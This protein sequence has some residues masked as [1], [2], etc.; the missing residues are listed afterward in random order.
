[1]TS[2]F[3]RAPM[4]EPNS[5]LW[6]PIGTPRAN[7][8]DGPRSCWRRR[9]QHPYDLAPSEKLFVPAH[10]ADHTAPRVQVGRRSP[11]GTANRRLKSLFRMNELARLHRLAFD[12]E[13]LAK[14]KQPTICGTKDL[15]Y[16]T[17][18]AKLPLNRVQ[19]GGLAMAFTREF[20]FS[21]QISMLAIV[22]LIVFASAGFASEGPSS[23]ELERF[24]E[25]YYG[26]NFDAQIINYRNYPSGGGRG[27]VS[28]TGELIARFDLYKNIGQGWLKSKLVG[29]PEDDIRSVMANA[30]G[31]AYSKWVSED[32]KV[33]IEL[34]LEYTLRVTGT[35]FIGRPKPTRFRSLER[36]S[37]IKFPSYATNTPEAE[38]KLRALRRELQAL[39]YARAAAQQ[40]LE[41]KVNSVTGYF[42]GSILQARLGDH[43]LIYEVDCTSKHPEAPALSDKDRRKSYWRDVEYAY[44]LVCEVTAQQ[45]FVANNNLF[46]PGENGLFKYTFRFWDNENLIIDVFTKKDDP[47]WSSLSST[48]GRAKWDG[49]IIH[50]NIRGGGL[51]T[52]KVTLMQKLRF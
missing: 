41:K 49:G 1:M 32:V 19:L 23:S 8:S 12:L 50:T 48:G 17:N 46:K 26:E 36:L 10:L 35:K 34:D 31:D 9:S 47:Y 43:S 51:S 40:R 24:V 3:T 2:P 16:I 39:S 37:N 20:S 52:L 11:S 18:R 7:S 15:I 42:G 30:Q 21:V 28:A 44:V 5:D 22:S 27:R 14:R 4:T 6:S 45:G 33:H 38:E 29:W 25:E 13:K